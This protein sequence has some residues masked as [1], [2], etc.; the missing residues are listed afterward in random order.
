M[1]K[2]IKIVMLILVLPLL[3]YSAQPSEAPRGSERALITAVLIAEAGGEKDWKRGL[4]AVYEVIW[5]RGVER[6]LSL[7]E[8]VQQRKQ[9]SCL[10]NTTPALLVQR[11]SNHKRYAWAHDELLKFPPLTMHTVPTGLLALST[12]RANHYHA[13]SVSPYWA[14][15]EQG[16][17]IGNHIFYRIK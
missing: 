2:T 7:A 6:R 8:V 1:K 11:M 3:A 5:T 9:F 13:K 17:T 16:K 4:A 12:N 10:N 14:K 15:G